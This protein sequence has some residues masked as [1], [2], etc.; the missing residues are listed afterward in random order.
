MYFPSFP[1]LSCIFA[2]FEVHF[3]AAYV[4]KKEKFLRVVMDPN[5]RRFENFLQLGQLQFGRKGRAAVQT[6]SD[7]NPLLGV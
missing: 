1:L 3:K 7:L 2:Q 6:V 4:D 5:K